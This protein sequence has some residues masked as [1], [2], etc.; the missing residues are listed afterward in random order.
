MQK[1]GMLLIGSMLLA[2]S[3]SGCSRSDAQEPDISAIKGQGSG[4][5]GF[6]TC[7]NPRPEICYEIYAPVCAS[8]DTGIR[9]VTT[10]CPS[11]E[12]VMFSNDCTAC[13][14]PKVRGYV[15]GQCP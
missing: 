6:V 9:C 10:P 14:D 5:N 3:L 11:E 4:D 1:S 2:F 7:Q 15:A 8:K 13:A 12:Q